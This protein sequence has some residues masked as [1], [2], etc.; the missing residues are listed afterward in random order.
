MN[1]AEKITLGL[2]IWGI[3]L[4]FILAFNWG[5]HRKPDPEEFR[6]LRSLSW[7]DGQ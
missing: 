4:L 5:A 1:F 2:S 7:K 6:R 3:A